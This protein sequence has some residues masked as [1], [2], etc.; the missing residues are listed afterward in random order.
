LVTVYD[1]GGDSPR[2]GTGVGDGYIQSEIVFR[3]ISIE[4]ILTSNDCS[5]SQVAGLAG[6]EGQLNLSS[7][8]RSPTDGER[9]AS[10]GNSTGS[11]STDGER[12]LCRDNAR[13]QRCRCSD[14]L[15]E[16]HVEIR[17]K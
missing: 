8:I 16:M 6:P 1:I 10:G 17:L 2:V 4:S 11:R 7:G 15:E 3:G 13:K 9:L 12:V 5:W 14:K